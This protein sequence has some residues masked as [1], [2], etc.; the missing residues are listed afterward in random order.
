MPGQLH[1]DYKCPL[2]EDS[3]DALVDE[4]SSEGVSRTTYLPRKAGKFTAENL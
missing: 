3:L 4:T 1:P 2:C